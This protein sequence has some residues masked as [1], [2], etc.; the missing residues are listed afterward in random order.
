MTRP[1]DYRAYLRA[2]GRKPIPPVEKLRTVKRPG[3]RELT[4]TGMHVHEGKL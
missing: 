4:P 1:V 2:I 3:D